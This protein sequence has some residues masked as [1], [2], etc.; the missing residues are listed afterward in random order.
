VGGTNYSYSATSKLNV[1]FLGR[2]S[3][4]SALAQQVGRYTTWGG[5]GGITYGI[6]KSMHLMARLDYRRWR[7]KTATFDRDQLGASVGF[8]WSP[9]EIPLSLF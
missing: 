5:G 4:H 8:A 7:V 2:I 1:G 9:G 6:W 3:S